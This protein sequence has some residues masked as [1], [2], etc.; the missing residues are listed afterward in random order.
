MQQINISMIK[1]ISSLFII[2]IYLIHNVNSED[3]FTQSTDNTIISLTTDIDISQSEKSTT[4]NESESSS[5][6][7]NTNH[8]GNITASKLK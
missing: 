7:N 1:L 2:L 3:L 4:T 8:P 5:T 6:M